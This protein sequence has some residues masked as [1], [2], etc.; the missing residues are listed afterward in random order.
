MEMWTLVVRFRGYKIVFARNYGSVEMSAIL[1]IRHLKV[2]HPKKN[3]I[4]T[5]LSLIKQLSAISYHWLVGLQF[6]NQVLFF[7]RKKRGIHA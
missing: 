7:L 5:Y 1:P 3:Q 2:P 4:V 6:V